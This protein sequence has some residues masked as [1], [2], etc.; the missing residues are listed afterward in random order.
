M[1]YL[2]KIDECL[3]IET[4]TVD[5][6]FFQTK[7]EIINDQLGNDLTLK[8]KYIQAA[9]KISVNVF[10]VKIDNFL[11]SDLI[12]GNVVLEVKQRIPD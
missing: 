9:V 2:P 5:F 6:L 1:D 12:F 7:A 3:N 11:N 10:G 8:N 4:Q